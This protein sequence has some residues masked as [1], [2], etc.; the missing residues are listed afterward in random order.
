MII[1][2]LLVAAPLTL[3][4][5]VGIG[6]G[7]S[8]EIEM[9]GEV[10]SSAAVQVQGPIAVQFFDLVEGEMPALVHSMT[11]QTLAAFNAKASLAGKEVLV[12]AINDRDGNGVCT[13]GEPWGEARGS[14]KDDDTVDAVTVE[15]TAG[16]C[17]IPAE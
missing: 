3:L 7:A 9:K 14:V 13:T 8:R 10:A 12:R 4:M 5:C 15:L 1:R 11:L 16:P 6:C 17:P 2:Q